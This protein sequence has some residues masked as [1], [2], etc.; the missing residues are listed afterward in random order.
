MPRPKVDASKDD[1]VSAVIRDNRDLLKRK[2]VDPSK[3]NE[4]REKVNEYLLWCEKEGQIPTIQKVALQLGV[5]FDTF[6]TWFDP[7]TNGVSLETIDILSKTRDMIASVM[8]DLSLMGKLNQQGYSFMA[9]NYLGLSK[10]GKKSTAKGDSGKTA[11]K[12]T[13]KSIEELKQKL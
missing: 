4:V 2:M 12:I 6:Q 3:P 9:S 5:D 13:R 11:K 10:E 8:T 1:V 7:K